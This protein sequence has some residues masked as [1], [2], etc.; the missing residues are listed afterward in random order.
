MEFTLHVQNEY[1]YRYQSEKRNEIVDIIKRA[2]AEKQK[3]NLPIFGIE[4]EKLSDFTTTEKDFKRG[5]SKFPP[6]RLRVRCEDLI[7]ESG[8]CSS[9]AVGE[10]VD[11]QQNVEFRQKQNAE[12]STKYSSRLSDD[13]EDD[14][15]EGE[16]GGTQE[17]TGKE[18][19]TRQT[20]RQGGTLIFTRKHED[21]GGVRL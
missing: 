4:K 3:A 19:T 5:V 11:L 2:F 20:M 13:D 14:D 1:D 10:E 7:K 21:K 16:S 17:D 8:S 12:R 6:E 15:D 9:T 18:P